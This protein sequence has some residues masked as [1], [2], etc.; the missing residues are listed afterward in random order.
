MGGRCFETVAPAPHQYPGDRR[1]V[2]GVLIHFGNR[3][4]QTVSY[5]SRVNVSVGCDG[6]LGSVWHYI[7]KGVEGRWVRRDETANLVTEA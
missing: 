5:V 1:E 6:H 7:R 4:D 3:T 2:K